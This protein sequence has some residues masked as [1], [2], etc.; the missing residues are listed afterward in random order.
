MLPHCVGYVSAGGQ[1]GGCDSPGA[2]FATNHPGNIHRDS[3][4]WTCQSFTDNLAQAAAANTL[5]FQSYCKGA[6]K[7]RRGVL[8]LQAYITD[9]I[10]D[11]HIPQDF[12]N[13]IHLRLYRFISAL[14]VPPHTLLHMIKATTSAVNRIAPSVSFAIAKTWA[15][16]WVTDTRVGA[17]TGSRCRFGCPAVDPNALDRLNHYLDCPSLWPLVTEQYHH[18]TGN[19]V[20]TSRFDMLCLTPPWEGLEADPARIKDRALCLYVACDVYQTV[21]NTQKSKCALSQTDTTINNIKLDYIHNHISESFN[22]L[23]RFTKLPSSVGLDRCQDP[24]AQPSQAMSSAQSV[25]TQATNSPASTHNK[26]TTPN[27]QP[28][29]PRQKDN[30]FKTIGMNNTHQIQAKPCLT[31]PC[32]VGSGNVQVSAPVS[33]ACGSNVASSS[34]SFE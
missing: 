15:N 3:K 21:S 12:A 1:S 7:Q 28:T 11:K 19:D 18:L 9:A 32:S 4:R 5:H 25:N 17:K 33:F 29:K 22:R 24:L 23:Q 31:T 26:A 10:Q 6:Q 34:Q 30:S 27:V 16:G 2:I 20:G 8:S 13:D 14:A